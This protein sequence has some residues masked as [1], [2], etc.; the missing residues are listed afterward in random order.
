M[1]KRKKRNAITLVSLLLALAALIGV[2]IWYSNK[3]TDTKDSVKDNKKTI[4]VA[5]IDTSKLESLHYKYG[6]A[7]MTFTLQDEV[8]KSK[9]DPDRPINQEYVS[10]M[11][12]II[13]E[14]IA[15]R[16][17]E[18]P[19]NLTDYGL[20]QP[21]SYLQAVQ[22]DGTSI[23]LQIGNEISGGG[24][25][26][27]V[28]DDNKVY[29]VASSYGT[30][31]VYS[32][33]D[34]TAVE[35]AP[36]I[37]ADK[38]HHID[39]S[40]RDGEEFELKYDL[41]NKLDN[42]GSNM[43]SWIILKPYEE[44]YTADGTAVSKLQANYTNFRFVN[45]VD[46]RGDDL[47][48]YGLED[49]QASI[50]IGYYNQKT[51]TLAEPEKD[52]NTGEEVT[53]KTTAEEK[54]IKIYIGN[55]DENGR[56]Y[57]RKEG[58][59]AVYTMESD[60]VNTMLTIDPF[61]LVNPYV[62]IPKIDVVDKIDISI[63]GENH[64]MEITR[65]VTGKDAEGKEEVKTTYLHDGKEVSEGLFKDIYQIMITAKYDAEIKDEIATEGLVPY[66]TLTYHLNNNDKKE[67]TSSYLPYNDS[68]YM[69]KTDNGTRFFAD[70]RK[71][72]AIAKTI[73]DFKSVETP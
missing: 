9:E 33:L 64:T 5:K 30:G 10:G 37:T 29:A 47:S 7:D 24:Y 60:N 3:D 25:Y 67:Y 11:L 50:Y 51:E 17:I 1:A 27:L 54:E 12:D 66:M 38:I 16:V 13:D 70:K 52:P 35:K 69:V 59:N 40:K 68:F 65:K 31:L 58:S 56:Y 73:L 6:D 32:N 4:S 72:E 53:E 22:T 45:C 55:V 19:D 43:F 2:Y 36:V 21:I 63:G 14:I 15:N 62:C 71:I 48:K 39:I 61:S 44:G 18:S 23:T 8:W 20:D 28:N 26:A 46:Y 41:G 49:P 42:S 57:V 34:M